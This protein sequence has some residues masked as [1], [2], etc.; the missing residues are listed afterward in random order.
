MVRRFSVISLLASV[1]TCSSASAQPVALS[2]LGLCHPTWQC[3]RSLR[4]FEPYDTIRTGWLEE[5]FG[6]HCPCA[7]RLLSLS[8]PKIVRIHISNGPCLRNQRCGPYEVFSG[9]TIASANRKVL[10]GDKRL[11]E[12]YIRVVEKL[13]GRLSRAAGKV[14]CYV[15]PCLECDLNEQARAIL[16][17]L[18]SIML[19]GCR[20]VDSVYRRPCLRGA[21]CEKHG[22]APRVPRPCIT[23]TD[24]ASVEDIEVGQF[25]AASKHCELAYIWSAGL[26]CNS[27]HQTTFVDP[28]KRDCQKNSA[29]FEELARWLNVTTR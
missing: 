7:E 18:T 3:S 6:Q 21:V 27:H 16:H 24:G 17:N 11:L 20:L 1:I 12:K 25:L 28:R 29:N 9:E 23:D 22:A 2:Y 14:T 8:K 19:P 26:N 15:S 10:R 13:R 5:T 4:V